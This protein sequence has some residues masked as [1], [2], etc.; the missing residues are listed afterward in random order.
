MLLKK[1]M[2]DDVRRWV[3]VEHIV[4]GSTISDTVLD[5]S[6]DYDHNIDIYLNSF[7]TQIEAEEELKIILAKNISKNLIDIE[8]IEPVKPSLEYHIINKRKIK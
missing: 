6:T 2:K 5:D 1:N 3:I 4:N 7:H 8:Y